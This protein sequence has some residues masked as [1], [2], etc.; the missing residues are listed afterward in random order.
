LEVIGSEDEPVRAVRRKT[1]SSM[2]VAGR[3]VKEAG[4]TA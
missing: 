3:M 4:P 1:D 2:V